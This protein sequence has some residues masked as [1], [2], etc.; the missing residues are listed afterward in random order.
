MKYPS[1]RAS[2]VGIFFAG[3]ALL[4]VYLLSIRWHIYLPIAVFWVAIALMLGTIVYQCLQLK[5]SSGYAKVVLLEIVVAC[6]VFHLLYQIPYY[7]L[8]GADPDFDMVSAKGILASGFVMGVPQYINVTSHWPMLHILGSQLSLVTNIDIFNIAKWSPPFIDIALIP[9]LYLLVRNIFNEERVA[10]LSVLL[11]AS[12]QYHIFFGSQFVRMTIALVLAMYCIYLYF[13]ARH[14][15]HP[16][17]YSALSIMCLV[18]TV[19]AHHLTSFMLLIFLLVHFLVTKVSALPFLRKVYFGDSITGGKITTSFISFAFVALFAHWIYV[20]M[21]PLY[22]LVGFVEAL[23]TPGLWG[24]R[25]FAEVSGI[26]PVYI[27]TIRGYIL[28]YGFYSFMLIS[29]IILLCQLLPRRKNHPTEMYSFTLF[30][31]LCGLGGLLMMYLLP[32]SVEPARFLIYGWLFA[33]APLVVAIL[34]GRYKWL[35]GIGIFLL[36]TFMFFNIYMIEPTAW[37]VRAEEVPCATSEEDYALANTF[38]FS[39][40][41]IVGHQNNVITIYDVHSNLGKKVFGSEDIDLSEYDWVIVQ[42]KALSYDI[43]YRVKPGTGV[44]V[45]MEQLMESGSPD[46]NKIYESDNLAVFKLRD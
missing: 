43:K 7:G 13:S 9:P 27:Q 10:L 37:D 16:V 19:F 29:G 15:T 1:S 41:T 20:V 24:M 40:G 44:S 39:S 3:T 5:L 31:F 6:F 8:R 32:F 11:F 36:I 12:L 42:K 46:R 34:K 25:T 38:D 18:G 4:I 30:L 45:Q 21:F 23:F 2:S 33:F 28:F 35:R 14:S 17:A 26:S 22:T